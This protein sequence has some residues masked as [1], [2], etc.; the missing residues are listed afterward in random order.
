[1]LSNASAEGS[2]CIENFESVKS[3]SADLRFI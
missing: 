1:M 2:Y 3:E